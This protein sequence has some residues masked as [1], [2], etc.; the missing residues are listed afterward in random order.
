VKLVV[1][2]SSGPVRADR[3][4]DFPAKPAYLLGIGAATTHHQISSMPDLTVTVQGYGKAF[5][6]QT[7]QPGSLCCSCSCCTVVQ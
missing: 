7:R 5:L 6:A 4:G 1:R 2:E 3:A